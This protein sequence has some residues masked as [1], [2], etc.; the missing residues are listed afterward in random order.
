MPSAFDVPDFDLVP[1]VSPEVIFVGD[2]LEC[3]VNSLLFSSELSLLLFE[4]NFE[5]S[6]VPF[7]GS[8][9]SCEVFEIPET[10]LED[11]ELW[12]TVVML[13]LLSSGFLSGDSEL[14]FLVD[15]LSEKL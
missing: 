12:S 2:M 1:V 9:R 14:S 15:P 8:G 4:V 5:L 7:D 3:E 10:F 6:V 13:G 11:S